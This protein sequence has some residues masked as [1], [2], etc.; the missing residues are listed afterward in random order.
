[1]SENTE[2]FRFRDN[3]KVGEPAAEHDKLLSEAFTDTG[4]L[5]RLKDT[6]APS[7][8][9]A[10]RTGSGKSALLFV[11]EEQAPGRTVRID[12]EALSLQ[13]LANTT[14]LPTLVE[15]GV[16]LNLFY[17]L[18]WEHIITVELLRDHYNLRSE[19][20]QSDFFSRIL[21]DFAKQDRAKSEALQYLRDWGE[22]FWKEPE[23]RIRTVTNNLEKRIAGRLGTDIGAVKASLEASG[24]EQ[25]LD[26]TT[27]IQ[28]SQE[29]VKDIQVKRLADT[30]RL[31]RQDI[32]T[33]P[34][35][36][37]YIVI[38]DLDKHWI[39]RRF[40]YDLI[41]AL[42]YVV[43]DYAKMDNIQVLPAL[44]TNL[45][46]QIR[47]HYSPQGEQRIKRETLYVRIGWNR[48]QLI[49]MMDQRVRALLRGYYGGEVGLNRILPDQKLHGDYP[50]DY[51]LK[52]TLMRPRG[53]IHYM[54][55]CIKEA[56]NK[57]GITWSIIK[58]VENQYSRDRLHMLED[59]WEENYPGLGPAFEIFTEI[60]DRF[61]IQEIDQ[62]KLNAFLWKQKE[63][64]S[65]FFGADLHDAIFTESAAYREAIEPF[66][67]ILYRIGFFGVDLEGDGS[68]TY[69]Y[70]ERELLDF[71]LR[72]ATEMYVHPAFYRAL[73]I[74]QGRSAHPS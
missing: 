73:G 27:I 4:Y 54:N 72:D 35:K 29:I 8:V 60:E 16:H 66:I 63:K 1:M 41:A 70:E 56:V 12:P 31:V 58:N 15:E 5:S 10:G 25:Q 69:V 9:V 50:E 30:K 49:R 36:P 38:D 57:Q 40:A 21:P 2:R 61:T 53:F 17:K 48:T 51:I 23:N 33:D 44:R 59:E 65:D 22:D 42:I 62:D 3:M 74:R 18:L 45:I 32:L 71:G 64:G 26:R 20:Q 39:E 34:Q 7:S 28:T 24:D 55:L 6:T 37:Y 52:R 43:G 67:E 68:P 46:D 13:Y 11:L 14:L 47:E 19:K